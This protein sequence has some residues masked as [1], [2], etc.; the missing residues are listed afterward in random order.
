MSPEPSQNLLLHQP[1]SSGNV[2][3]V[4]FANIRLFCIIA[5]HDFAW[6]KT[7]I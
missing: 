4:S 3:F 5:K 6:Q 1:L 7:F 2:I